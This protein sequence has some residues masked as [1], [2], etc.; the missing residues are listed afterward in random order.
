MS[1]NRYEQLQQ[2]ADMFK[3]LS[4]PHRLHIFLRLIS[5]CPPGTRWMW[6]ASSKRYVGQ[7]AEEVN[8]APSTVS[9]HIK[10]LRNAGLIKV[11]RCGKN[12]ECWMNPDAVRSLTDL[13]AGRF[14]EGLLLNEP[15]QE[16]EAGSADPDAAEA[17]GT[18]RPLPSCDSVDPA[19]RADC[20]SS[21]TGLEADRIET[22]DIPSTKENCHVITSS[23]GKDIIDG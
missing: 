8:I 5:C 23:G 12:I 10:E 15:P 2:F 17:L 13:L 7:L 9:H 18:W 16:A 6:D 1:N 11:A 14:P 19:S 22:N 20:C 3:A 21:G 4:N